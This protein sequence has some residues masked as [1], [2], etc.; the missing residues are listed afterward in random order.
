M[1]EAKSLKGMSRLELLAERKPTHDYVNR[2]IGLGN[3]LITC[4]SAALAL[5]ALYSDQKG[6][7]VFLMALD[8]VIQATDMRSRAVAARTAMFMDYYDEIHQLLGFEPED[9][10][11]WPAYET[12]VDHSGRPSSSFKE[13]E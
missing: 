5:A 9:Y 13:K 7:E 2:L 4:H 1:F 12:L 10:E 11:E 6:H 8:V 3:T